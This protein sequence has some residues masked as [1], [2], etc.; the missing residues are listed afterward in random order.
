MILPIVLWMRCCYYHY[1]VHYR[2]WYQTWRWCGGRGARGWVVIKP[3]CLKIF[4]TLKNFSIFFILL[5]PDSFLIS[6]KEIKKWFQ[7][8][9]LIVSG[10]GSTTITPDEAMYKERRNCVNCTFWIVNWTITSMLRKCD[11]NV[12][13]KYLFGKPRERGGPCELYFVIVF[14]R[15]DPLQWREGSCTLKCTV[16]KYRE[17][18][19][20]QIFIHRLVNPN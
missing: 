10:E 17:I 13:E 14:S 7:F 4:S 1:V 18:Q 9:I 2:L 3:G 6:L 16:W 11:G 19:E 8:D 20:T 5:K 12:W 15:E